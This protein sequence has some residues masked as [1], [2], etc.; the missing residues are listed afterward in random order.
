[1]K[2]LDW[3]IVA[4]YLAYV[5]WDGIRLTKHSQT[6]EGYF[7]ANRSLPW[8]AV[9]LSVMA[10]QLSAITLVGTTGQ[11]YSDGM[12]FIQF[13]YGLPLA[14][15]I[16]CLT[17]VPFFHRAGVY[18]AY[19]YLE[20]RFD[21]KVRTLTSFF[22]LISRGLGVGVI[23]SAP[24]I[25]LSIV[26][27]WN[28]IFT[29]F[30]IGMSTT[31]YTVFG[32]V[33][34]VTWTDVKQMFVIFFGLAVC[35]IVILSSFP[36]GV[37]LSDGLHLAGSLGK[38]DTVDT[39]FN[40]QEKY[41]IW[42]GLI[43]G[44]FLMLGYFGCDQSQVQ[45]YLTAKSIDEGRTSLLMS[46]FLKIPMQFFILLIG[47]LVFVFYQFNAP[48]IIFNQNE[49]AKAEQNAQFQ[50][51]QQNYAQ[52]HAERREAAI[53]FSSESAEFRQNYIAADK[54]FNDSR[55][56]AVKFIRDTSD[57]KF[58][59]VN[60]VFP[61]FVLQNMPM[62]VIGLI[63]AAIFAAAMSSISAE[64]NALATATTLDFY[65]RL[66]KPD[67]T[68]A[69]T[70]AV[71]RIST[72]VWGIFACIVAIFASNLGSLIEVVNTFGSFFYGSLL[73]VFVLAFVV[74]RARARGAFFGL[75]FGIA[76][77][78]IASFYTNIEF[79]WFNVI[80]CLVTVLFGY[81]ISLT[82]SDE[83]QNVA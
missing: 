62:G 77:V 83:Q 11:A 47:V 43:G 12:R 26:F 60:Y 18:T 56:E 71:G 44:L 41:T 49:I 80:G 69:Q 24:S 33:Q 1:M 74:K 75:L 30:A 7:L 70:L 68:D 82:V 57:K 16:L 34:A 22:F 6:A 72:F 20:K 52:A 58:N 17:V 73:G 27:G 63:I 13:Y 3:I 59:D 14:M 66:Y 51:I 25:V 21:V 37:S 48:P 5:I 2:I 32:G 54:K 38:L 8:W 50:T 76:S 81:L 78:W 65:R 39:S 64:L 19:E 15:I 61:T 67:A 23:I 46:A 53:K 35:L 45:R 4:A 55:Q 9:G 31:V 28:L 79:L 29:I 40:L 36:A 10:T 42:S